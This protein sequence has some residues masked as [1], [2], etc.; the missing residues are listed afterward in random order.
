MIHNH[1]ST[2]SDTIS[3][4]E[5]GCSNAAFI[6]WLLAMTI[7]IRHMMVKAKL[8]SRADT[9]NSHTKKQK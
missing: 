3:A 9:T 6:L 5:G 1:T 4:C 2:L 8:S 7:F